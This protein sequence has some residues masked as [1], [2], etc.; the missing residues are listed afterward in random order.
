MTLQPDGLDGNELEESGEHVGA[1]PMIQVAGPDGTVMVFQPW[2]ERDLKEAMTHLPHPKDSGK[3]LRMTWTCS[4]KNS[5]P[6]C[7]N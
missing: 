1:F 4:V 7:K 2:N 6:P 5:V 3:S